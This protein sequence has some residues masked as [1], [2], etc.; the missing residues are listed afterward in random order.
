ML[1]WPWQRGHTTPLVSPSDGRRRWRLISSRP[2][3]EI[4]PIWTRAR[5][6]F[7]ASFRRFSTAF[8]F[9]LADISMKSITIKPPMSRRRSCRAIS[10]A[11]SRLVHRAVSSISPPLVARAEL[12]SIE[13]SASVGSITIDPPDGRRTSRWNADSIW[14]SI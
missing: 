12:M 6:D 5:S 4:R 8:W 3:R 11:A 13:T 9:L 7:R 2:K 14:P 1:P 10:S